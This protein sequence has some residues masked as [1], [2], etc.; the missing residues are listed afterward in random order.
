M[1]D[2][3][4]VLSAAI[5]VCAS[6]AASAAGQPS[7]ADV[8]VGPAVFLPETRVARE[9]PSDLAFAWALL[10]PGERHCL[11]PLSDQE[12]ESLRS[13]IGGPARRLKVG[14]SRDI[15]PIVRLAMSDDGS[16]PRSLGRAA[17]DGLLFRDP[18][19]RLTWTTGFTSP[20]ATALRLF[21]SAG[22]LPV[23]SRIYVYSRA[24]EVHGPYDFDRGF[25]AGGFW[26]NTVFAD[27]IFVEIQ[28]PPT[29]PGADASVRL[30][31]SRL[32]HLD[33]RSPMAIGS[34]SCLVD[35]TCVS[36]SEFGL[37]D[38][39]SRSAA[40][41]L[42]ES[43]GSFYFCSGA[44]L[45]TTNG[46]LLPYL[47]TAHHCFD[48]QASASSLE[49]TWN[50]KT[51]TCG[52]GFPDPSAFPRTLGATLLATNAVSDFTFVR[53]AQNPPSGSVLLGWTTSDYS[54]AEGTA[55]YRVSYPQGDPQFYSRHR[56]TS[57]PTP[58]ACSGLP[59]G[60]FLYSKNVVGAIDH[61]SSGSPVSTSDGR[62]IGQLYGTCGTDSN[63]NCDMSAN[64]TVDGAF[65]VTYP[66]VS[67]WLSP[68]SGTV[69]A[70][71]F[72][73]APASPS[74]GQQITF[75]DSC[76][77]SPS[78]WSWTF[79][80]GTVSSAENPV[81]SYTAA[82]TYT[83]SLTAANSFGSTTASRAVSVLPANLPNLVPYQPKGWSAKI[84][85]ARSAGL[86]ADSPSLQPTDTLYVSWAVANS[87]PGA[88]QAT[89][90]TELSVDGVLKA[91]WHSDP[92][93]NSNFYVFVTDFSIGS[94]P[95]GTHTLRLRADPTDAVA[96]TNE[97]DNDFTRSVVIDSGP[98]ERCP[99]VV[100]FR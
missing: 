42:F 74:A 91:T 75:S 44:L 99:R 31:I 37:I 62:V 56:I 54:S 33:I 36:A 78:S 19:G 25:P 11:P 49:A 22:G 72:T 39:A 15:S 5:L 81:K 68:P 76:T 85:V 87:G 40:R 8:S 60:D 77:G 90:R 41:L 70:A 89:F 53:L 34:L 86:T 64:S 9:T 43:G 4:L 48:S 100:R 18:S 27:E 23:G 7:P 83:V 16:G 30:D 13:S 26:T 66:F 96:E 94:L 32:G 97:T 63:D 38:S 84:V 51:S 79:G 10:A 12:R 98:C 6:L 46:S 80:D 73:Y 52:G 59:Q 71:G 58:A 20:G 3:R 50:Y 29:A 61:G 57:V 69:P 95:A 21:F 93:L 35:E 67:Q 88:T 65:R 82:G 92:P 47:L 14:I 45:N 55:T 2:Q 28:L 1:A 17:D 24:G